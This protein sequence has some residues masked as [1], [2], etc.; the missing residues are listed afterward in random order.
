MIDYL[1]LPVIVLLSILLT[2]VLAQ[3]PRAVA[4]RLFALYAG[5][6]LLTTC[7]NLISSTTIHEN[8]A[9]LTLMPLGPLLSLTYLLLVWLVLAL[10][11]PWRYAQ[12]T[13]RWLIGLP[14][15]LGLAVTLLD[16]VAGQRLWFEGVRRE[17]DG[18]FILITQTEFGPL[19]GGLIIAQIVPM[20]MLAVIAIRHAERRT[21]AV[22]LFGGLL[23]SFVVASAPQSRDLPVLY[24]LGPLPIY[25]AFAWVTVRYQLFRPSS[26]I[27]QTAIESLPDGIVFLDSQRQVRYAN[28]AAHALL[29]VTHPLISQPLAT[30]LEQAGLQMEQHTRDATGERFRFIRS[31]PHEQVIEGTE[32][33]VLGD[34]SAGRILVLHDATDREQVAALRTQNEEQRRLLELIAALEIPAVALADNVLL[35]P[36]VGHIDSHRAK[37]LTAKL[38][39][40]V[41]QRRTQLAILDITGVQEVDTVVAKALLDTAQ[42]LRLLGCQVILSGVSASTAMTLAHQGV[43]LEGVRTVRS[44]QEALGFAFAMNGANHGSAVK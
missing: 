1:V 43:V 14:Y 11:L 8:L 18:T 22:V 16:I 44:P 42:A 15:L 25:L 41:H 24:S 31:H 35:A 13:T 2:Y 21:P 37:S 32:V 36:I 29:T 5:V 33:T 4:N 30:I 9:N 40:E 12:P 20:V 38:L 23:F 34:R 39:E 26:I 7:L 10:F 17:A 28:R 27:M 3:D 6:A 19:L